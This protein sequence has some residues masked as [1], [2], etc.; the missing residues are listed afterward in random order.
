M[1]QPCE[2]RNVIDCQIISQ[3]PLARKRVQVHALNLLQ[4][5]ASASHH[6][7]QLICTSHRIIIPRRAELNVYLLHM[8]KVKPVKNPIPSPSANHM[9]RGKR[10]GQDDILAEALRKM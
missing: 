2:R 7:H 8:C 10:S 3:S 1:S 4:H 9:L 6:H 5:H